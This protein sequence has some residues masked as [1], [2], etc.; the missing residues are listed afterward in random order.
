MPPRLA[1][2]ADR[3]YDIPGGGRGPPPPPSMDAATRVLE[4]TTRL[5]EQAQKAQKAPRPHADVYE[6]FRRLNPKEFAGTTDP[7]LAE[8]WIQSLEMHYE[9]LQMRDRDRVRC[10]IYMLRD[11]PSLWW[12]GATHAVHLAT[13]TWYMFKEMFHGKYFPA[14]VRGCLMR[15]FMILRQGDSSVAEFIR[16]FDRGCHFMPIIARDAAQKWRHLMDGLRPTIR[17]DVML[18]R[19]T[20]YDEATSCAF[21]AEQTLRDI[22]FEMQRKRH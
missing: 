21:Q 22:D 9:Y 12:E 14:D 6:Q 5:M 20:C 18:M 2:S 19:P 13:L 17:R 11:D 15:E 3:Q 16:K 7:F 8:G 1:H 4:G 10:A